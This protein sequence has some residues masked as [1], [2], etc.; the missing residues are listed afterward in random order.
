MSHRK[1]IE[2]HKRNGTYK[3]ARHANRESAG[4]LLKD[5]PPAPFDLSE[6]AAAVYRGEGARLIEMR[7]LKPTDLLPL[8]MYASE[9]GLYISE[10]RAARQ[11]GVILEMSNGTRGTSPH[12]KAAETALKLASALGDKL[13]LN[14]NSRHRLQGEAAFQDEREGAYIDPLDFLN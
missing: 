3:P 10:M 7:M 1:S 12:R 5:L 2:E 9:T 6:E 14:P 11:E 13:G 4:D 8:A